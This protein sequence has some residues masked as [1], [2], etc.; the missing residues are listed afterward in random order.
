VANL[1]LNKVRVSRLFG[2]EATVGLVEPFVDMQVLHGIDTRWITSIN[3]DH[4]LVSLALASGGTA[5]GQAYPHELV[6][7]T[8]VASY[9]GWPSSSTSATFG[10][11][12]TYIQGVE[13]P[14]E[15]VSDKGDDNFITVTR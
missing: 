12:G 13:V 11:D 10:H 3:T 5:A 14:N 9:F 15:M 2:T 1:S 4:G 8:G 6:C 7:S